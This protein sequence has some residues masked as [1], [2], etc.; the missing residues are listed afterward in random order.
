[1]APGVKILFLIF[2]RFFSSQLPKPEMKESSS[3]T[4]FTLVQSEE[5]KD[6][7]S[8]KKL[9]DMI[10]AQAKPKMEKKSASESPPV[11]SI[12]SSMLI[13]LH[14]PLWTRLDYANI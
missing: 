2:L 6:Y 3:M 10:D 13:W 4:D 11:P 9:L 1:M 12:V 14:W 5:K 7:G 8:E